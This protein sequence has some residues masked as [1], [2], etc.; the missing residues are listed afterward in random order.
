VLQVS[1][2]VLFEESLRYLVERGIDEFVQ[3]GP[4]RSVLDFAKRVLP[5]ARLLPFEEAAQG[6]PQP[7]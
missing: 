7:H 1:A 6:T 2:P 4:G 3:C 5:S